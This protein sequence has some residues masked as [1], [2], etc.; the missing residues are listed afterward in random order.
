MSAFFR[1]YRNSMVT[2]VFCDDVG[3]R[4]DIDWLTL[5]SWVSVED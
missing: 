2:A 5:E 3:V 4:Y 1:Y